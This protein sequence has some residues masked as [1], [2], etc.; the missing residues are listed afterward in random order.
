MSFCR[1][2]GQALISHKGRSSPRPGGRSTGP[3]AGR[4]ALQEPEPRRA[5]G[6]PGEGTTSCCRLT[7]TNPQEATRPCR[8]ENRLRAR[9]G[10]AF[11]PEE[12]P[13]TVDRK[14]GARG[15]LRPGPRGG[16]QPPRRRA[17]PGVLPSSGS[18]R[19]VLPH[20]DCKT[21]R[22]LRG[23]RSLGHGGHGPVAHCFAVRQRRR[24]RGLRNFQS[25]ALKTGHK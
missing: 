14:E 25:V 15:G 11:P 21:H 19:N 6:P 13:Y 8:S 17:G 3:Q 9:V 2:V 16:P 5:I 20:G 23:A 1:R 10:H 7:E 18:T 24:S 12:C 4:E 22:P